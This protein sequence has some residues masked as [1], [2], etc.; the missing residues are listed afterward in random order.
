MVKIL[1]LGLLL[2]GC[3]ALSVSA[4]EPVTADALK[5]RA[6]EKKR[7]KQAREQRAKSGAVGELLPVAPSAKYTKPDAAPPALPHQ[8]PKPAARKQKPSAAAPVSLPFPTASATP[9][10][11]LAPKASTPI[12]PAVANL[13]T[14]APLALPT[15][16]PRPAPNTGAV[17]MPVGAPLITPQPT[18]ASEP[19]PQHTSA[20][21]VPTHTAPR[22]PGEPPP[23]EAKAPPPDTYTPPARPSAPNNARSIVSDAPEPLR[24]FGVRLG[25]WLNASLDRD[26][27]SGDTGEVELT[28]TSPALGTRGVVPAGTLLFAS[29]GLNQATKRMEMRIAH[30][31]TPDGREF[32]VQGSVFDLKKTAGLPG[33]YSLNQKQV[34]KKGLSKGALAALASSAKSAAASAGARVAPAGAAVE[35]AADGALD[36]AEETND[37]N[38]AQQPIIYV[39]PQAVLIRVDKQ[40]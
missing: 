16:A 15:P 9:Q 33:V 29:K 21:A 36:D 25:T 19:A 4:A 7:Q 14:P 1:V 37:L 8:T 38:T 13:N 40:F 22:E 3:A 26:A 11:P 31:I 2:L 17:E 35:A 18:P 28:L 10:P 12:S 34:V 27:T 6:A 23:V 30:G 20:H 5:E 32:T 39:S 24:I